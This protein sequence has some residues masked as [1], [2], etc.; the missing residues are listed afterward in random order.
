MSSIRL[1]AGFAQVAGQSA[2]GKL[3]RERPHHSPAEM[4]RSTLRGGR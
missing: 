3:P 2:G 4:N 1:F